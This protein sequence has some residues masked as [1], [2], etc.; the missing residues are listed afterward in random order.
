[1]GYQKGRNLR[2]KIGDAGILHADN[3]T[4]T[5]QRNFDSVLDKDTP[6][7]GVFENFEP[8]S[9]NFTLEH[10]GLLAIEGDLHNLLTDYKAGTLLAFDF[11]DAEAGSTKISGSC[12]YSGVTIDAPVVGIAK[13]TVPLQGTGE[14]ISAVVV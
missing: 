12:Y 14:F 10:S 7:G 9:I 8:G 13:L 1:M 3:C 11:E 2:I 6:G 5:T 4:F